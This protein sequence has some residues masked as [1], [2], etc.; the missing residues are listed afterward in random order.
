[1]QPLGLHLNLNSDIFL[2]KYLLIVLTMAR[3]PRIWRAS[4]TLKCKALR[5]GNSFLC[6][7]LTSQFFPHRFVQILLNTRWHIVARIFLRVPHAVL[8]LATAHSWCF[9]AFWGHDFIYRQGIVGR[10]YRQIFIFL[11]IPWE[12]WL[13]QT[14]FVLLHN[15]K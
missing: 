1:M 10:Y 13:K 9:Q 4:C 7:I 14:V 15:V 11:N 8:L 6:Q 2:L 5:G 12:I 3:E